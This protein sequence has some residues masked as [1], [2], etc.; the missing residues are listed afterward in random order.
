MSFTPFDSP[1]HRGLLSD[2]ELVP[3]F[4][5]TAQLRAMLLFE[6]AL[7]EAQGE[8][9]IIPLDSA[10][11]I[12]RAAREV[13]LDPAA[14]SAGTAAAGVQGPSF[15]AEFRRLMG[16]PEHA[17]W[18]HHGASSQDLVDSGLAIRLNRAVDILATRTEEL[19]VRLARMAADHADLP[20]A[21]RT[22]HQIATPTT[23]GARVATWHDPL[24]RHAAR[25]RAARA[26]VALLSLS[27][28]GGTGAAFG[29]QVD[30]LQ[31]M[32]AD[33]LGLAHPPHSRNAVRDGMGELAAA[34]ALLGGSLGK[35]A[36]DVLLMVQMSPPELRLTAAGGSSTMPNKANPVA[37][38]T[39]LGL[40]RHGATMASALFHA[41][42]AESDRDGAAWVQE[43]LALPQLIAATGAALRHGRALVDTMT[44][45][46]EAMRH[47][48]EATRGTIFAEAITFALAAHMPRPEAAA[49]VKEACAAAL[50]GDGTL[51]EILSRDFP[52][53]DWDALLDPLEQSGQARRIAR[54][55]SEDSR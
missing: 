16:A 33:K 52:D 53:L 17:R 10:F 41:Q 28:A 45:D 47:H 5:D 43:W 44:P 1:M 34:L 46:A 26:S 14:L 51:S 40:A 39:L 38:E 54:R 27:G 31:D 55:P 23:F 9:G 37:A 7:A 24:P 29:P 19:A 4:S 42:I 30:R 50:A 11:F 13:Q 3:L 32:V 21:A 22:R 15:V 49:R 20:M 12:A 18:I 35:M 25:L 6:G 36:Q 8:L 48:I 2:D